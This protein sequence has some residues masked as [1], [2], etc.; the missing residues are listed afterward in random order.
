MAERS[1]VTSSY[2]QEYECVE[3]A[4]PDD[5][6]FRA[7]SLSGPNGGQCVEVADALDCVVVRDSK[8]IDPMFVHVQPDAF[9]K[10]IGGLAVEEFAGL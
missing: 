3:L 10:F 5:L 4:P 8:N 7:S 6:V 1:F 9:T 2:C